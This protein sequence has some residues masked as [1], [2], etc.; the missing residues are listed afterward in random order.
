[1][2]HRY[3]QKELISFLEENTSWRV[4]SEE[5]HFDC[6]IH[7]GAQYIKDMA[8]RRSHS[9]PEYSVMIRENVLTKSEAYQLMDKKEDKK[10]AKK[11]LKMLCKYAKINYPLLMLKTKIYSLRWW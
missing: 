3:N 2:Y 10:V 7:H 4:N 1:M 11:E 9:M 6:L 8:A 5:E